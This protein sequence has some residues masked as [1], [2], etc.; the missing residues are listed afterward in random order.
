MIRF[1]F[2]FISAFLIL[3]SFFSCDSQQR[4]NKNL[5]IDLQTKIKSLDP[6]QVFSGEGLTLIAQVCEPLFEYHYLN[7]PHEIRPL[8]AK[9]LPRLSENKKVYEI[10][11]KEGIFYHAHRSLGEHLRELKAEDFIH[12]IKRLALPSKNSPG[13]SYFT[14]IVGFKEFVEKLKTDE[15][16]YFTETISGLS[17]QGDYKLRIELKEEDQNFIYALSMPFVCPLPID[18]V[19][20]LNN[21]LEIDLIGTGPFEWSSLDFSKQ[22]FH[23]KKNIN[24][25]KDYYPS[26]GDR[27]SHSKNLLSFKK[28]RI[29]FVQNIEFRFVETEE[30][31]IEL[32]LNK[33]LDFIEITGKNLD[34]LLLGKGPLIDKINKLGA[35]VH[36]FPSI[37][38][39]WLSFNMKDP[40]LGPNLKLRKAISHGIN[41]DK[42]FDYVT[43]SMALKA[44]SIFTPGVY[45]Y[46][47]AK[48]YSFTYDLEL[49]KKLLAEAGYPNGKGLRLRYSTRSTSQMSLREGAFIR[50]QLSTLGIKVEIEY[51]S[52]TDFLTLGRAGKLQFFTDNWIYDFPDPSNMLQLLYSKNH[53]GINKSAFNDEE[54]DQLYLSVLSEKSPSKKLQSMNLMERIVY[55]KLP[56]IM[57]SYERKYLLIHKDV[58]NLRSSSFIKNYLKYINIE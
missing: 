32:F 40:I 43:G 3:L 16:K 8:L 17:T 21:N 48:S 23:L 39:R 27:Y 19:K 55:N 47:P 1:P 20:F 46:D 22:L 6:A 53:P 42:Y 10:E 13:I 37:T 41:Y 9:E 51:L 58:H 31:R 2:R 18:F 52:F 14:N 7:R 29:P 34:E 4:D 5:K 25:R 49:A 35:K 33:E 57:L 56:W 45:G 15:N 26:S 11:I 30:E 38:N 12:Q 50:E 54:Y 44:H 28:Q 24:Y 36:Y